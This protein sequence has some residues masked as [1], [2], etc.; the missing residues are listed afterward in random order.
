MPIF[1]PSFLALKAA[2]RSICKA[3]EALVFL[4][5]TNPH[6]EAIRLVLTKDTRGELAMG[7]RAEEVQALPIQVP[8]H[9]FIKEKVIQ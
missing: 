3:L 2:R 1:L 7:R 8:R 6:L 5:I 9:N 4:P